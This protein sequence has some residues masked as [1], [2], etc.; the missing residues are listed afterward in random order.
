[1][2]GVDTTI[3]NVCL[4]HIQGSMTASQDQISWVLTTYIV[5]SAIMMPLT[6]WLAGRFGVKYIFMAS[7]IGF[8]IAS[9][10]CGGAT[11]STCSAL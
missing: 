1:M 11:N 10:L 3:A 8:T 7:V 9:A 6:G 4:P 2:Q 5:S